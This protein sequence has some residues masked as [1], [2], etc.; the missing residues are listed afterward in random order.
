MQT[1]PSKLVAI[2]SG[3][4]GRAH[5]RAVAK[6]AVEYHKQLSLERANRRAQ[7]PHHPGTKKEFTG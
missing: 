6:V 2:A 7:L 3:T 4:Q 1:A 5:V